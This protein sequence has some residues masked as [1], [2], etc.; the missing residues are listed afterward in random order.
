[1][2]KVSLA[3]FG[4]FLVSLLFLS[5]AANT[6]TPPPTPT[7]TPTPECQAGRGGMVYS[8]GSDVE[9]EIS[10]G[11]PSA[12]FTSEIRLVSPGPARTVGTSRQAGTVV[13]LGKFPKGT[14]LIFAIVVNDTITPGTFTYQMGPAARNPDNVAHADVACLGN[15]VSNVSFEDG[16][17]GG[18]NSFDDVRFQVRAALARVESVAFEDIDSPLDANPNMGGGRRIYPDKTTAGD[19]VNRRRVRV[20]ANTSYGANAAIFFRSFDLDDPSTDARPVDPNSSTGD[21]NRGTPRSGVLSQVNTAGTANTVSAQTDANGVA[22]VDFTVTMQPGDNFMVAASDDQAY[23]NA[24]TVN[25]VS[26]RDSTGRTLPTDQA[27]PSE[28][29]TVWRRVH[30]EA[31]SMGLVSGNDVNGRVLSA[32]PNARTNTTILDVDQMLEAGRFENG[33]IRVTGLGDFTVL[34]NRRNN[35]TIQGIVAA[36]SVPAAGVA[37]NLVDDDD[38][39][40]SETPTTLHGDDAEN[41]TNADT[42]LLQDSDSPASNVFAPAYVRPVYDVGDNNDLVPFVLNSPSSAAGLI[43]TYDF[44][45]SGTEADSAFWTVYLLGAY[46]SEI[47]DDRDPERTGTLGQVDAINGQGASVFN[48]I[49]RPGEIAITGVVN[50]GAT[51]A[52][53]IGH[54][55]GG[56]HT[57]GGLMAQSRTRTTTDFSPDTLN[58]IRG[59]NHP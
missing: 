17:G 39:N 34:D 55:F 50:N 35:V 45:A 29:L 56:I 46:Q 8:R 52:H 25:T 36:A 43:A 16:N 2:K 15:G 49:L 30:L 51:A 26:L 20:R 42:V 10:A 14:E 48:E 53:E 47:T 11:N 24:L 19:T 59:L 12:I 27:K 41:I 58:T 3:L 38:F 31:E 57:D 18:D 33:L 28:M 5:P 13:N 21:D 37:F 44:D 23:L 9:V 32:N 1:M 54:L 40:S 4:A 7:P 22:R 6:Q